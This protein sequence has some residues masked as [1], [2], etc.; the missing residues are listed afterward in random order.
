MLE[1]TILTA[2][3]DDPDRA[4]AKLFNEG[5]QTFARML[6]MLKE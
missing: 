5:V 4:T 2:T 3:T 1:K 6:A